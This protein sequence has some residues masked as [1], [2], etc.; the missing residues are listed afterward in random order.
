M[1]AW[2]FIM[3]IVVTLVVLYFI[4]PQ[5]FDTNTT[6]TNSE[7]LTKANN[8][9]SDPQD[10]GEVT[11]KEVTNTPEKYVNKTMTLTSQ[12]Q[13][14]GLTAAGNEGNYT[15][16]NLMANGINGNYILPST[17]DYAI[18]YVMRGMDTQGYRFNLPLVSFKETRSRSMD[19]LG[20][21]KIRGTLKYFNLCDCDAGGFTP[22]AQCIVLKNISEDIKTDW[23]TYKCSSEQ[24][25]KVYYF[26]GTEPMI[27]M[28]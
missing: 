4:F 13:P 12:I 14:L 26:I 2:S 28:N 15:E 7:I 25:S 6:N 18:D 24:V 11:L 8:A 10:K 23:H 5:N 3:G 22:L 19:I 9:N 27:L 20:Q 21:Y 1:G 17:T 16:Y